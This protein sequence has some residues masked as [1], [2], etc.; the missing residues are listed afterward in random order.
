MLICIFTFSGVGLSLADRLL[1]EY[2]S[3]RIC[4]ACRN[5]ERA[6]LAQRKLLQRHN[7]ADVSI[8]TVD[9]SNVNSVFQASE[10]IME[11]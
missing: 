6:K 11:R 8:I 9:T 5:T 4:L 2:P 7:G 10:Q 1:T 3:I